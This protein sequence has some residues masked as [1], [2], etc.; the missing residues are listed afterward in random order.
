MVRDMQIIEMEGL[1]TA[2]SEMHKKVQGRVTKKI[3]G[4]IS[5]SIIKKECCGAEIHGCGISGSLKGT[6][7]R[8]QTVFSLVGSKEDIERYQRY[9][10]RD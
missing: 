10:L 1:Q 2:M 4:I 9:S 8:S 7:Q 3:V 5:N 6:G